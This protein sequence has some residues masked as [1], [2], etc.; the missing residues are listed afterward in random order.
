MK[1]FALAIVATLVGAA[2]GWTLRP[3]ST[4]DIQAPIARPAVIEHNQAPPKK[5]EEHADTENLRTLVREEIVA[6]LQSSGR[7][8]AIAAAPPAPPVVDTFVRQ[9]AI[10]AVDA[11][12]ASGQWRDEDRS[13]FRQNMAK[14][15]DSDRDALMRKVV[16]GMNSGTIE[17]LTQGSPL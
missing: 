14:L 10:A 1:S 4:T 11:I 15:P 8:E 12:I 5:H 16:L 6:A 13:L 17:V 3:K 2:I 9:D 7:S